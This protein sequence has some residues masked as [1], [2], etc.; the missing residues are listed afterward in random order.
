MTVP[1]RVADFLV[2][3]PTVDYLVAVAAAASAA[4]FAP[5]RFLALSETTASALYQTLAGVGG[6]LVSIGSIVITLLFAVTPNERLQLVLATV[7]PRLRSITV[8]CLS[9]LLVATVG[10]ALLLLVDHG[11]RTLLVWLTV[12]LIVFATCRFGRLWWLLGRVLAVLAQPER[13]DV[14]DDTWALPDVGADDYRVAQ[15]PLHSQPKD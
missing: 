3:H 7:G 4:A 11:E 10:L 15:R 14:S 13:I 9:G 1:G 12:G 5:D 6:I 2:D 8:S